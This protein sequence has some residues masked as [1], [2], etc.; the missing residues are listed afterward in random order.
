[1]VK[2]MSFNIRYATADDGVNRWVKRRDQVI[3]RI[4]MFDPDLLGLQEC[5]AGE[6]ADF[7]Q[8]ALPSFDFI[9]QPRG[10]HGEPS[11]EM[12]PLLYKQS[13]F[14]EIDRGFFWLS[15]TPQ[16]PGSTSWG[17]NFPRTV[18][19]VHL[20]SLSKSGQELLFLNTHFD[21]A[22][23]SLESAAS[24]LRLWVEQNAANFPL[25]LTGDFNTP[26]NATPHLLLTHKGLLQDVFAAQPTGSANPGSFHDYG[27][28]NPPAPIDWIL[29]SPH[30]EVVRAS[31]DTVN[32]HPQY[33]SDHFPVRAQV[34]LNKNHKKK[35]RR[36]FIAPGLN[37]LAI[38]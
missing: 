29:V 18:T 25:I 36:K 27:R 10:G 7:V 37:D 11:A 21:Y 15:E 33:P 8:E 5:R 2:I 22:P 31:I 35:T 16:V 3:E 30:F 12:A 38:Y 19:W 9:G 20:R 14:E 24:T 1:M 4:Q 13:A 26:R 23:F 6:Q 34:H 28:L 17:A 32:R